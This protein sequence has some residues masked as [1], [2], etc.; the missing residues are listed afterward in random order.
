VVWWY[1]VIGASEQELELEDAEH[2]GD[3]G[4]DESNSSKNI[5]GESA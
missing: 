2:E 1:G 3:K 4:V 5:S